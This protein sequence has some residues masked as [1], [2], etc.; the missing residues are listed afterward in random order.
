[1]MITASGGVSGRRA[2]PRRAA[3][4]AGGAGTCYAGSMWLHTGL[5]I[6]LPEGAPP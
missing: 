4:L 2:S 5:S 6:R 1:M 3:G